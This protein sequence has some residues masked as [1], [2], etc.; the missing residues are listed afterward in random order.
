MPD[1][2]SLPLEL[3]LKINILLSRRD[4]KRY[5][6]ILWT[7]RQLVSPSLFREVTIYLGNGITQKM[8][9][10]LNDAGTQIKHAIE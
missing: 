2:L 6:L 1:L 3:V 10:A 8:C 7:A 9:D 4:L 5:S